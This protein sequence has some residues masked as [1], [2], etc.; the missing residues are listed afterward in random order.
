MKR[1]EWIIIFILAA[2]LIVSAI[3]SIG[4]GSVSIKV[5]D[6]LSVL[7]DHIFGHDST[8]SNDIIIWSIRLPR[9]VLAILAG[10]SLAVSGMLMQSIFHNPMADPYIIGVSSGAS[11]GG[12]AAI[13]LGFSSAGNMV[14]LCSFA[15][16]LAATMIVYL[17]SKRRGKVPISTLLLTGI[18]VGG[19]LSAVTTAFLLGRS[20][21]D[22]HTVLNWL[23]GSLANRDW[24][25]CQILLPYTI[26]GLVIT[27]IFTRDLNILAQGDETA[28]Y[29]GI[30]I[31]KV[32]LILLFTAAM[33]ASGTV[34]V[35]GI[36]AFVGLIVPHI[37]RIITGPN[38]RILLPASMLGGGILLTWA[39][40]AARITLPDQEIPIGVV[41]SIIGCLFFL[42]LLKRQ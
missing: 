15:G 17:L 32:R 34:A 16:G 37:M 7:Q 6:I 41:T 20:S 2:L 27:F 29:L 35:T 30:P 42:Y 23:M 38:H 1:K 22:L 36:I 31:E 12:V 39:D 25:H 21:T 28:H 26:V 9:I 10:A 13:L 4:M 24:S 5:T 18:A 40:I 33:L 8:N 14:G 19:L 11:L 3:I